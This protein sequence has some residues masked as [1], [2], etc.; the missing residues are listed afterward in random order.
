M[1]NK[2]IISEV[3][4]LLA[5]RIDLD[6]ICHRLKLNYSVVESIANR[7]SKPHY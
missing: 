1:T 6:S 5:R 4:E 7:Y 2:D 3:R